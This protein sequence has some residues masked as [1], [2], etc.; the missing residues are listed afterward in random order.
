MKNC[1]FFLLIVMG[2]SGC[3]PSSDIAK[4][5][6]RKLSGEAVNWKTFNGKTLV[7]HFWATWCKDCLVELPSLTKA[8]NGL[9]PHEKEQIAIVF[10]SDEETER[11]QYFIE[12]REIPFFEMYRLEKNFKNY[13]VWHIPQTYVFRDDK[14]IKQWDKGVE[15]TTEELRALLK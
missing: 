3:V 6:A 15:W 14:V 1:L 2:I 4:Y 13:G 10:L 11:I 12:N 7:L 5:P 9:E 8:W